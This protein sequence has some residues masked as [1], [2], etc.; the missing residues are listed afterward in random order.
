[1]KSGSNTQ[2]KCASS[3]EKRGNPIGCASV[4]RVRL[5]QCE[6]A[7]V[8]A[9]AAGPRLNPPPVGEEV[10]ITP[11]DS[12]ASATFTKPATFAPVM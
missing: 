7:D 5:R 6:A 4:G 9:G 10:Q 3:Y 8:C 2:P 1:M 11:C 12:I